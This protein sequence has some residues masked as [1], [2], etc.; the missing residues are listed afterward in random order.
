M[1]QA[2]QTLAQR[3]LDGDKRALARAITLVESD[4]PA[5][6]ELVRE[7]FPKTGHVVNLEEPALFN[8]T[9][10]AFLAQVEAGRW[11][12]RDPRSIRI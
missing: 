8:Q 6:W 2:S 4:D 9:L 7:V 5:G 3:L 12:P 10:D 1:S 11:P